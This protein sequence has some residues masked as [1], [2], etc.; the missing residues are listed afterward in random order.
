MSR[1]AA[2][3]QRTAYLSIISNTTLVVLKLIVGIYVGAVSLI[4]EALHSGVDLIAAL[5][6][7]W[8]V[9]K[10]VTPPDVE[11]DYGH[12]KYENLSAAVEA[13]LIVAAALGI[14]YEAVD[15][16]HASAVPEF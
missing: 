7:F 9:R 3:K 5:I 16:F 13:V 14:V 2:L 6:A 12:G 11:H 10:S 8:A 15:K 1:N 4:S